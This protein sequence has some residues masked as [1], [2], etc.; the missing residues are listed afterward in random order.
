MTYPYFNKAQVT[1]IY[2]CLRALCTHENT[3]YRSSEEINM[4]KNSIQYFREYCYDTRSVDTL[5]RNMLSMSANDSLMILEELDDDKK[6]FVGNMLIMMTTCDT[7]FLQQRA[8]RLDI[9]LSNIGYYEV[10]EKRT[11]QTNN[12]SFN[13]S[14][15][16][17]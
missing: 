15:Y 4:L 17:K 12:S 8:K 16:F 6:F 13:I 5:E 7:E 11:Q 2:R 9:I 1:A 14:D 3:T 10:Q